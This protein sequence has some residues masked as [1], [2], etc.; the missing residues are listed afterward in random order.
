MNRA[1]IIALLTS[2]LLSLPLAAQETNAMTVEQTVGTNALQMPDQLRRVPPPSKTA[3]A[4]DLEMQ[5]DILRAEKNY[6]DSLDYYRAAIKAHD[7][8]VLENKAG[9]AE[10]QMQHIEDAK[11]R[12]EK[13]VKLDRS[14]PDALNNLGVAFYMKK[15]Y[16]K[17]IKTYSK[18]IKERPGSSSFHSNLGS[19]YFASKEFDKAFAEYGEAMQ[20]D[21]D[22][23]TRQSTSGVSAKLGSPEDR[24][25][26]HFVIA[27]VFAQRGDADNCILYLRKAMED[28]FPA[29]DD[30]YKESEFAAIVKD[31]RFVT[32]MASRPEAVK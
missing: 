31:P 13:A 6:A 2:L 22:I 5:A 3:S 8:A 28:G 12:F 21:P 4:K 10:L 9:I 18:A 14:Y 27:K 23:F 1:R 16:K 11:D 26:F 24:A 25:K 32:L 20:I 29:I 30:V 17:A 7:S 15:N 19:A